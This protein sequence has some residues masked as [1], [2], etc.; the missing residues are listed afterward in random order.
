[1]SRAV[2]QN[3][4]I[5]MRTSGSSRQGQDC[6]V[7]I[8]HPAA[9]AAL[10]ADS[11]RMVVGLLRARLELAGARTNLKEGHWG[12]AT[13]SACLARSAAS[14]VILVVNQDSKESVQW[15]QEIAKA[16]EHKTRVL[17][18]VLTEPMEGLE[19]QPQVPR[20]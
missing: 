13:I 12:A 7:L 3:Q 14:M 8:C 10:Q 5:M 19:S 4:G 9:E 20:R 1:M 6:H 2:D 18:L 11:H 15:Q 17:P 16:V